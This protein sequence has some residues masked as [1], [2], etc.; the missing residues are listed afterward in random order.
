[1]SV[2]NADRVPDISVSDGT[3]ER[4]LIV[5]DS[6]AICVTL[7]FFLDIG[8]HCDLNHECN[9][10]PPDVIIILKAYVEMKLGIDFGGHSR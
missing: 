9:V 4:R 2:E 3:N 6:E 5:P 8:L 1:M 7:I 10:S